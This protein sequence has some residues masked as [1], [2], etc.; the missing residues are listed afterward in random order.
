MVYFYKKENGKIDAGNKDAMLVK[1]ASSI[2][3]AIKK[4]KERFSNK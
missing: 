2:E 1:D 3:D 4:I